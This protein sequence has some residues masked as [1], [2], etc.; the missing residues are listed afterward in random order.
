MKKII[1]STVFLCLTIFTCTAAGTGTTTWV[2]GRYGGDV[3]IWGHC[4]P[5]CNDETT[6]YCYSVKSGALQQ[7]ENVLDATN[8]YVNTAGQNWVSYQNLGYTQGEYITIQMYDGNQNIVKNV[9][10]YYVSM[11]ISYNQD[12]SSNHHFTLQQ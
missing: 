5:I 1:L 6:L 3:T 11:D 9:S 4:T 8:A 2:M 10:G 12:G 7:N